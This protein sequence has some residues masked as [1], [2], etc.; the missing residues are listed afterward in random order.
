MGIQ[1]V[2]KMVAF[3]NGKFGWTLRKIESAD[4]KHKAAVL[5]AAFT[6]DCDTQTS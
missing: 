4:L 1:F 3:L 6:T 5:I 2:F